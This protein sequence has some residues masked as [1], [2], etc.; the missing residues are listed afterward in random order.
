MQGGEDQTALEQAQSIDFVGDEAGGGNDQQQLQ[1]QSDGGDV[2]QRVHRIAELL[3]DQQRP[4]LRQAG[5]HRNLRKNQQID[6][7]PLLFAEYADE[8]ALEREGIADRRIVDFLFLYVEGDVK[9]HDKNDRGG[10]PVDDLLAGDDDVRAPQRPQ[11]D[12]QI[13][14]F[15]EMLDQKKIVEQVDAVGHRR[16]QGGGAAALVQGHHFEK[17]RLHRAAECDILKKLI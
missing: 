4:E 9:N 15:V 5:V 12:R 10:A 17:Q 16:A 14:D 13:V 6:Q 2:A 3:G 8:V 11:A 7:Q 1:D